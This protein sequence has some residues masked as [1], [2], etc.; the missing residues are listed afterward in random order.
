MDDGLCSKF[1]YAYFEVA[2]VG[3]RQVESLSDS[4]KFIIRLVAISLTYFLNVSLQI[5]INE[6]AT[7]QLPC[8]D[9]SWKQTG[10]CDADYVEHKNDL[11]LPYNLRPLHLIQID[12]GDSEK[13]QSE[14][15]LF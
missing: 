11:E 15:H 13:T 4:P 14:E 3:I 7:P 12:T 8:Y 10:H 6:L 2:Q 9:A 1:R 5:L